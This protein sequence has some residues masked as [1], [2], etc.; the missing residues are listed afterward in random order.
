MK[1]RLNANIQLKDMFGM[2]EPIGRVIS[3]IVFIIHTCMHACTSAR[4]APAHNK[5]IFLIVAIAVIFRRVSNLQVLVKL[6]LRPVNPTDVLQAG[7]MFGDDQAPF[8]P[9]MHTLPCSRSCSSCCQMILMRHRRQ[10][11]TYL[12]IKVHLL[13]SGAFAFAVSPPRRACCVFE[14]HATLSSTACVSIYLRGNHVYTN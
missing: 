3:I 14:P 1:Q 12:S 7:A 10:L 11:L 4:A 2:W 6:F 13:L 5:W 9:G 8:I